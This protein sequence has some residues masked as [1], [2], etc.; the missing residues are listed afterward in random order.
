METSMYMSNIIMTS[1]PCRT[2]EIKSK[3]KSL[4][5][6]SVN[7]PISR[8]SYLETKAVVAPPR[9]KGVHFP[10]SVLL[11]QAITEGDLAEVKQLI[12]DYG[13]IVVEEREPSGLPPVM[14]AIF[15]GQLESLKLLV[16]NGAELTTTDPEGWTAL[17]VAA[18]MDDLEA[19]TFVI[20][21]C[22]EPMTCIRNAD[23]Q[24]PVDLAESPE[25]ARFLL[26]SDLNDLR[27]DN[28]TLS[29]SSDID[30][31]EM[32]VLKTVR[33]HYES[34]QDVE[35]LNVMLQS[36]TE[37]DTLLHLAAAKN[38]TRLA[39]YVLKHQLVDPDVRDREG[40]TPIHIA[41]F[42][43]SVDVVLLLIEYGASIHTLTNS[44]EKTS[45]LTDNELILE[46]LHEE[47]SVEY[48]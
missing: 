30:S 24:R 7:L 10:V 38:Y 25:M 46:I 4:R 43:S 16:S 13:N 3:E 32:S 2:G 47:E 31:T 40:F 19:A 26:K 21:S 35:F 14:R 36:Q 48:I 45:D 9:R 17:H 20:S 34:N 44:Y 12:K 1:V 23:G 11:Q 41:A 33:D 5:R 27:I 29:K 22:N 42:N 39:Y 15:E 6:R 8:P 18:A 37:F 28:T